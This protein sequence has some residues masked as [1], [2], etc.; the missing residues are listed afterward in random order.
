MLAGAALGS[1][2]PQIATA[3]DL[4]VKAP[5]MMPAPIVASWSGFYIGGNLGYVSQNDL[6][7]LSNFSQ[8][9]AVTNTPLSNTASSNG[10][11]GG[12]QL[13]Y[14]WQFA[15]RWVVGVEGDWDW[16]DTSNGFCRT[17]DAGPPCTDAGRGFLNINEK[18]NWLASAR[19]RLGWTWNNDVLIYGTAGGAWGQVDTT[20]QAS[21]A[22]AGCGN[23]ATANITTASFSNT[24]SGWVAGAGVEGRISRNWSAKAEWL[25]YDLGTLTTAFTAP[26]AVGSYGV[27]Y[28]RNLTYETIRFGLNYKFW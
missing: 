23:N 8:P 1:V 20:L 16:T 2:L 7:G 28:S 18:T 26:A 22:V 24:A 15:P 5:P 25:H 12:F 10:F 13:G 9:A 11:I 19:A 17:T 21:C 14:N 27:S 3:A 6:S 4:P